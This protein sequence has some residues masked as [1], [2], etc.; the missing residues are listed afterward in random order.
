[1]KKLTFLA[2]TIA[3]YQARKVFCLAGGAGVPSTDFP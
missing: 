2:N 3:E 1:M